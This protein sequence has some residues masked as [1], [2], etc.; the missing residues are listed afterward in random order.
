M[1]AFIH[2]KQGHASPDRR[3][4][5]EL[6]LINH[7]HTRKRKRAMAEA[8]VRTTDDALRAIV[9]SL[10][11]VLGCSVTV[12]STIDAALAEFEETH[13]LD[14]DLQPA[15][16]Q[17]A[18]LATVRSM[19][20]HVVH[21][22]AEPLGMAVAIARW[23][24]RVLVIGPYTHEALYPETVPEL[25]NTH[26]LPASHAQAY[27][28]YR[29]RYA[30]VDAEYVHR[31]AAAV[32]TAAG[33]RDDLGALQRIIAAGGSIAPGT[34][35]A[36]RSAPFAAIED[37]YRLEQDFM[38]AVA[39][40]STADALDALQRLSSIPSTITY[41]TT[42][43]LG[44]TILRIMARV[45][46][47]RGGVPGVTIDAISQEYAQRLHRM[48]HT[49]DARRAASF[50][51]QMVAAFCRAVRR[52]RRR[53]HPPIVRQALDQIDLHL[54]R[55]VSASELAAALDVSTSTLSRRF[56]EATGMT[57][58]QYAARRRVDRA[59]R[60]L[61]TTS[62]TVRDIAAFVGYED[63]NYFVKVFRAA[64][65][66]TPTQYRARRSA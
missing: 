65:G 17:T 59:A 13:C 18:L 63:A 66:M 16:T 35:E 19:A 21:E 57:V 64:H 49:A 60:L 4:K 8:P 53:G 32:L 1:S 29:T 45:A 51:E 33:S 43:F 62:R 22:I 41:L 7:E 37:R 31:A 40:G 61:A 6:A 28:L 14:P 52:H 44:T 3:I 50:N 23:S 10:G 30:I 11:A 5:A 48:G 36:P 42:P 12:S 47:Q 55:P 27:R 56:K 46:A 39:E 26:V 20:P 54:S 24:D 25:V 2:S 58:A 9:V 15:F 38:D 34:D